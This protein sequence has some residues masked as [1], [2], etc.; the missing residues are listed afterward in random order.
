MHAVLPS[1]E[2]IIA[3]PVPFVRKFAPYVRYV[4][5]LRRRIREGPGVPAICKREANALT[6]ASRRGS[7][8]VGKTL[9]R[10]KAELTALNLPSSVTVY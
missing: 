9:A 5:G 2:S 4:W 7:P 6:H 3:L 1:P 8:E 10:L